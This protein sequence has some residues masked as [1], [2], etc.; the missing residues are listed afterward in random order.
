MANSG[1]LE[2]FSESFG[3]SKNVTK[4]GPSGPFFITERLQRT[5][6]NVDTIYKRIIF[7][8]LGIWNLW[9]FLN[10]H[11][12]TFK[13]TEMGECKTERNE[14]EKCK[15]KHQQKMEIM[16]LENENWKTTMNLKK[17]HYSLFY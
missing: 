13:T 9:H 14:I 12:P 7:V 15:I 1:S 6:Q 8:N 5:T 4:Y 2:Y 17:K 10:T 3:S 11:V 16:K